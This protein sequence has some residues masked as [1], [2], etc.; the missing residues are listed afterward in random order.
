MAMSLFPLARAAA[1]LLG[2]PG[3]VHCISPGLARLLQASKN[4]LVNHLLPQA[5]L[6]NTDDVKTLLGYWK[7]QYKK[8]FENPAE[9]A[10]W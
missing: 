8:T 7:T 10:Q 4:P 3:S 6:T 2:H 1:M 9:E 5:D